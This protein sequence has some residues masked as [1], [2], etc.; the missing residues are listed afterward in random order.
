MILV[1]SSVLLDIVKYDPTWALRSLN[2]LTI[3]ASKDRLAINDIVYAEVSVG[4]ENIAGVETMLTDAGLSREP[5]PAEALFAAGK[6]FLRY[7]RAGGTRT[8]VLPDFFIGAH[9]AA[10]GWSLLTRDGR[11]VKTYFSTVDV[12]EP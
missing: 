6:A 9:A 10:K 1:D 4:F 2:A 11:R 12:I 7:R 5:I 8:G 3:L